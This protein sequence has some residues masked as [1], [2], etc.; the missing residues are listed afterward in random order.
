[1]GLQVISGLAAGKT[2]KE[3]GL[4]LAIDATWASRQA[5]VCLQLI[6]ARTVV[7]GIGMLA[8]YGMIDLQRIQPARLF[9]LEHGAFV[10]E[11]QE[12]TPTTWGYTQ[13]G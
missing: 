6:G 11:L 4:D 2:Y 13:G 12:G 7:Q 8:R 3:I 10:D 5:K 9:S 1:L